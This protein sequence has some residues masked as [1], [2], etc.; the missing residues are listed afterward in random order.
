MKSYFVIYDPLL[1]EYAANLV[2]SSEY[3]DCHWILLAF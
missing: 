3:Y 1:A 2:A